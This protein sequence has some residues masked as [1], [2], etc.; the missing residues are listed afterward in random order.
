MSCRLRYGSGNMPFMA[1]L[2]I[3]SV[4]FGAHLQ[5]QLAAVDAAMAARGYETLV[6]HA[7]EP[8][9]LLQDDQASPFR[10]NPWFA[11]LVAAAPAPGALLR[12]R[13]AEPPELRFV[14]PDDYWHSPPEVPSAPW[15]AHFRVRATASHDAALAELPALAGRAAWL[16]ELPAPAGG[17]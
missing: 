10:T 1:W 12:S 11:W 5:S 2:S 17:W 13:R 6:M 9:M 7:G 3:E 15:T 16:G 14:A 8:R 4:L